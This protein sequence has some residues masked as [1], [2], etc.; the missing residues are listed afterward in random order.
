MLRTSNPSISSDID[1]MVQGLL[2]EDLEYERTENRT[3]HRESLVRP[4]LIDYGSSQPKIE[5]FSRNISNAGLGIITD[6]MIVDRSSATLLI[7]RLDGTS[8]KILAECRWCKPYGKK[9][10]IS[11]W[12]FLNLR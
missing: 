9:W 6:E 12:Q 7:E 11:G 5:A 1:Q 8:V 2:R 3:A 4:V 10:H